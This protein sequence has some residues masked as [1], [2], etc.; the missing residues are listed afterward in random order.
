MDIVDLDDNIR[1]WQLKGYLSKATA[2]NKS[3]YHIIA[4]K[5]LHEM[6]PTFQILEEV[7]IPINAKETLYLDFYIPLIKKCVE[8]H[9]EQHY[10]FIPFYHTTKLNFLKA[11]KRDK[12]KKEWCEKNSIAYIELPYDLD[13][14][15]WKAKINEY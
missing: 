2:T 7:T 8:V 3:S 13:E 6:Y 14:Q 12:Q 9:G 4:R 11:Q 15:Q 10:K 1:K 5:I